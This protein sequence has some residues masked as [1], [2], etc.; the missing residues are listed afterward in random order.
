MTGN[1]T[2]PDGT[3]EPR[4]PDV[5]PK[6]GERLVLSDHVTGEARRHFIA[7]HRPLVGIAFRKD[8]GE[9]FEFAYLEPVAGTGLWSVV[10]FAWPFEV[11]RIRPTDYLIRWTQGDPT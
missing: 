5:C 1:L 6:C 8:D 9:S 3:I 2:R 7:R 11:V 4:F 10:T